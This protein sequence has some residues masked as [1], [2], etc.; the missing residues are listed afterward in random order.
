MLRMIIL[1]NLM[2]SGW[3]IDRRSMNDLLQAAIRAISR[4]GKIISVEQ[5]RT[6]HSARMSGRSTIPVKNYARLGNVWFG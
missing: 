3:L 1:M 2:A 6:L 5:L 4:N